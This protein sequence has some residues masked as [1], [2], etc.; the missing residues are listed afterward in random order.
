M[1]NTLLRLLFG[2]VVDVSSFPPLRYFKNYHLYNSKDQAHLRKCI[3]DEVLLPLN[4][5][6]SKRAAEIATQRKHI[7]HEEQQYATAMD[8]L[9]K[10]KARH[11]KLIE[12]IKN[13]HNK[14]SKRF[15]A[16]ELAELEKKKGYFHGF[17]GSSDPE[18][19]REKLKK[20]LEKLKQ[21]FESSHRELM[22]KKN[23]VL[24]SMINLDRAE[25]NV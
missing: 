21:D 3:D 24:E 13:L 11:E 10:A 18:Q 25:E 7:H 9:Q 12:S 2:L 16:E 6:A 8:L 15:A 1:G 22:I 20:K 14:L 5:V 17:F 19:E 23:L 4:I